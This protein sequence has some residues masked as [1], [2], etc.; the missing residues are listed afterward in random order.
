MVESLIGIIIL[1]L[2][3]FFGI[4]LGL[5]MISVGFVGFGLERGWEASLEM[6]GQ[7]ILDL[8]MNYGFSTLPL[9]V[10]MGTFV[11][12]SGLSEDLYGMANAWLGHYRGGLAIATIAACGGFSA[13]SGSSV[14]TAATMC[15]V[16][17]PPMRRFGYADS[18]AT[19]SIAAGGTMGI[20]I[21]PSVGL[22]V[23]GLLANEDIGALFLA[24]IIP[25]IVTILLYI[26]TIYI[27]TRV[28]STIGPRGP[29]SGWSVRLRSL[30]KVWG[31]IALFLF[32]LGGIYTGIFTPTEAG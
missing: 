18:L 26:L 15:K 27:Q 19:G 14:A 20:L 24:G 10:L 23:Y 30:F 11:Y 6:V 17:L 8:S 4:P 21:P 29:R 25:G 2:L 3:A 31:V 13:V 1:L 22:V 9:F 16:A 7:I 32:I 5:S 28:N 12:R